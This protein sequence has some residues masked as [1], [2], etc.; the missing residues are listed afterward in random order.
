MKTGLSGWCRRPDSNRHGLRHYPLKIACLPIPPLR[1]KLFSFARRLCLVGRAVDGSCCLSS[2]RFRSAFCGRL[3]FGCGSI[4]NR[5][6]FFNICLPGGFTFFFCVRCCRRGYRDIRCRRCLW[7]FGNIRQIS[8]WRWRFHSRHIL[9]S[10]LH[11]AGRFCPV[12]G[13]PGKR[14]CKHK[15]AGSEHCGSTAQKVRRTLRT[16]DGRGCTAA[17][18]STGISA[19]TVLHQ[20]HG[21]HPDRGQ[22]K[23]DNKYLFH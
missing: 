20:D 4:Y 18:R 14:Q 11:Q 6:A 16:E 12:H 21:N 9:V 1:L 15:P 8:H 7:H 17:E 22:H 23:N 5:P 2:R 13:I 3:R 10:T 19:F